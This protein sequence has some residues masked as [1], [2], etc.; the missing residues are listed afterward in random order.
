MKA[1][2]QN[3][4]RLFA[5]KLSQE[6]RRNMTLEIY[7]FNLLFVLKFPLRDV[8]CRKSALAVTVL[9]NMYLRLNKWILCL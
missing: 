8:Y 1:L 9:V 5:V 6:F 7:L 3:S 2:L 4:A